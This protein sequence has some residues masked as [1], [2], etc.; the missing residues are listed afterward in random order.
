MNPITLKNQ[1]GIGLIE[2][3]VALLILA[4]AIL[5]FSA[6]QMNAIRTTDESVMRSRA[7][8]VMRGGAE[9][10]RSN[11]DTIDFFKKRLNDL[12]KSSPTSETTPTD[13][14]KNACSPQQLAESDAATLHNYAV[15][16]EVQMSLDDCPGTTGS[17]ARQCMIVSWGK[18]VADFKG[19]DAS[20]ANSEGVYMPQA[21]CFIMEAY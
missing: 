21:T 5:G 18:T 15:R 17:E 3:L 2:V 9:I 13:C 8:T 19:G 20:C 6:M 7:V 1:K 4:V 12:Q 11:P 10:M 16:N 14:N